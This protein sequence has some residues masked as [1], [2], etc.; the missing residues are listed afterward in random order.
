MTHWLS[1]PAAISLALV[2][3]RVV[4]DVAF[5]RLDLSGASIPLIG[6]TRI[7]HQPRG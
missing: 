2:W 6:T 1:L 5:T 3:P 4:E 7:E